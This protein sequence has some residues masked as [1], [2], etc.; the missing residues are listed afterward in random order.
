MFCELRK[1]WFIW[2]I[3]VELF[4]NNRCRQKNTS[5][6]RNLWERTAEY[7]TIKEEIDSACTTPKEET[8]LEYCSQITS[9][10][11]FYFAELWRLTTSRVF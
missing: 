5:S 2:K 8:V 9:R 7:G 1:D 6:R 3:D 11:P 4:F 10:Y